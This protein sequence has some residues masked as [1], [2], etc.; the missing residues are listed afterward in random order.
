MCIRDR[1]KSDEKEYISA[2]K[3]ININQLKEKIF[4]HVRKIHVKRFPYNKF[5]YPDID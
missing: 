4:K 5:L 3:K 1:N 2:Q